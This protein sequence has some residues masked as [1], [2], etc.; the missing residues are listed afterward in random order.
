MVRGAVVLVVGLLLQ[1]VGVRVGFAVG[2]DFR[3]ACLDARIA[4]LLQV[5]WLFAVAADVV[6]C[7]PIATSS[8][9]S[10]PV[11]ARPVAAAVAPVSAT[12]VAVAAFE[13]C[14]ELC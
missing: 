8:S 10:A 12:V 7:G 4:D 14:L 5:P 1:L 13:Q 3:R 9:A 11:A 2:V 6:S